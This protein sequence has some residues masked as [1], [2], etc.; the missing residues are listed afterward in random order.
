M[1]QVSVPLLSIGCVTV[2]F[3]HKHYAWKISLYYVLFF[4]NGLLPSYTGSDIAKH[5]HQLTQLSYNAFPVMKD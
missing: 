5:N 4:E 3:L 2:K 1:D